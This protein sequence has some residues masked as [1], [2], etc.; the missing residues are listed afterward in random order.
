MSGDHFFVATALSAFACGAP[1]RAASTAEQRILS[2]ERSVASSCEAL[3]VS[4]SSSAS[5]TDHGVRLDALSHTYVPVDDDALPTF[6]RWQCSVTSLC[7]LLFP[8]VFR[9]FDARAV[10]LQTM[11][12]KPVFWYSDWALDADGVARRARLQ[13]L[14]D[15]DGPLRQLFWSGYWTLLRNAGTS[16]HAVF[17]VYARLLSSP[18]SRS[19]ADA[20]FQCNATAEEVAFRRFCAARRLFDDSSSFF[21]EEVVASRLLGLFGS[22]DLVRVSSGSV[23]LFDWKRKRKSSPVRPFCQRYNRVLCLDESDDSVCLV[24]HVL[25]RYAMQMNL[26][27]Y[28]LLLSDA[29]VRVERASVVLFCPYAHGDRLALPAFTF[30]T[31]HVPNMFSIVQRVLLARVDD[32]IDRVGVHL[33]A[34]Y[35][36]LFNFTVGDLDGVRRALRARVLSVNE[37]SFLFGARRWRG[38]GDLVLG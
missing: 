6:V 30:Q 1:H 35:C 12:G 8:A 16:M 2:R 36:R 27:A 7:E 19:F 17:E 10:A 13:A 37:S 31:F 28:L 11:F 24:D 32:L 4:L 38:V 9:P 33:D 26:Y 15:D 20:I 21:P 18:A 34:S 22:I 14:V 3:G 5:L 29:T 23:E 25:F